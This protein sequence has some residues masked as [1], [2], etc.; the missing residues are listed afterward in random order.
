MSQHV[1]ETT[2]DNFGSQVL[3]SDLPVLVDF[4][5]PWCAPCRAIAPT[6]EAFA[7]ATTGKVKVVKHNTQ[8]HENTAVEYGV[9]AIPTLLL[10]QGGKEVK[11]LV[12]GVRTVDELRKIVR[13]A[14][15]A[16]V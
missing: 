1:L 3:Q 11:R 4:W 15:Q 8:D 12:G 14:T 16:D 13:E 5:A 6:I 7:T 9:H 10:F 2:D